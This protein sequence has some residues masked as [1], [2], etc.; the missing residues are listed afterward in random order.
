M[1]ASSSLVL[2]HAQASNALQLPISSLHHNCK[3]LLMPA[4][5]AV[6]AMR[7]MQCFSSLI[8]TALYARKVSLMVP[9]AR[10]TAVHRSAKQST[11]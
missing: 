9:V 10:L 1:L 2:D 4:H 5:Q 6:D 8:R 7:A 3:Q 11:S